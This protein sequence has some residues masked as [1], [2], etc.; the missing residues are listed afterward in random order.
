MLAMRLITP[1]RWCGLWRKPS[2]W[3]TPAQALPT[4]ASRP[5]PAPSCAGVS[6]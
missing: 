6:S 4:A 1:L 2:A 5:A 3:R